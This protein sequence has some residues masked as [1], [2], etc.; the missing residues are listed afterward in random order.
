VLLRDMAQMGGET[1]LK[2]S[3]FLEQFANSWLEAVI[4]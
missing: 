3:L 4:Q 1:A 2:S